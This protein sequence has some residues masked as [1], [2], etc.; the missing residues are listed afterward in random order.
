MTADPNLVELIKEFDAAMAEHKEA[1]T[2]ESAARSKMC[3]A[4]NRLNAAQKALDTYV[5]TL[6]RDA[7]WNTDWKRTRGEVVS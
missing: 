5:A 1:E 7:P 3:A 2:E 6:K 4:T